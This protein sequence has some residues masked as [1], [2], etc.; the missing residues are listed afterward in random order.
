MLSACIIIY[1]GTRKVGWYLHPHTSVTSLITSEDTKSSVV[2]QF[3]NFS[4]RNPVNCCMSP[5]TN[6][7]I[8]VLSNLLLQ[9]M[10][11]LVIISFLCIV[12]LTSSQLLTNWIIGNDPLPRESYSLAAGYDDIN[13]RIILFG[14]YYPKQLFIFDIESDSIIDKGLNNL[15]L[16]HSIQYPA[17]EGLNQ[18]Y[19]QIDQYLYIL[20]TNASSI[21]RLHL[22]SSTFTTN[23]ISN[24]DAAQTPNCLTS[25]IDNENNQFL[26]IVS[27]SD[28]SINMYDMSLNIWITSDYFQTPGMFT[29]GTNRGFTACLAWNNQL[30]L[31]GGTE[32]G[33]PNFNEEYSTTI[34]VL[35]LSDPQ[36]DTFYLF[37]RWNSIPNTMVPLIYSR[38]IGYESQIFIIGGGNLDDYIE[39]SLIYSVDTDTNTFLGAVGELIGGFAMTP[40]IA[41]GTFYVFGGINVTSSTTYNFYQYLSLSPAPTLSP[42]IPTAMPTT[43]IPTAPTIPT[44][45][46]TNIPT[47]SPS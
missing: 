38:V 29:N 36:P 39:N 9:P 43:G 35:D 40:I 37:Y 12:H 33:P 20:R 19:T 11:E 2:V 14:G 10:N 23:Y 5:S 7:L 41:S 13:D 17:Y 25:F 34:S 44:K 27:S 6:S 24:I 46:P 1:P 21:D 16:S 42:T 28:S 4:F 22:P 18:Y 30:Y 45:R 15:S 31:V 26:F 8:R 32:V 47:A 3:L